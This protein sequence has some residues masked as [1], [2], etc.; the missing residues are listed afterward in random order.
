MV[1]VKYSNIWPN[2]TIVSDQSELTI[3]LCQLMIIYVC[4]ED[5]VNW[6]QQP[7]TFTILYTWSLP[8][9]G[10]G[11]W[12]SRGRAGPGGGGAGPGPVSR[13][14]FPG[15]CH[16]HSGHRVWWSPAPAPGTPGLCHNQMAAH[17]H[18]LS[19]SSEVYQPCQQTDQTSN[20]AMDVDSNMGDRR[21]LSARI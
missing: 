2:Q 11:D 3:L 1:I 9:Q 6:V 14:L 10:V 21:R 13:S 16:D 5:D 12:H 8:D 18:Q 19:N 7:S 4:S 15:Q 17:H 20:P